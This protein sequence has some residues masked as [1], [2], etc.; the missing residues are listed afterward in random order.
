MDHSFLSTLVFFTG[1][2]ANVVGGAL[3]H[4]ISIITITICSDLRAQ[5]TTFAGWP[6]VFLTLFGAIAAS[7]SEKV[8]KSR[9]CPGH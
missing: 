7:K 1:N 2:P 5:P 9:K 4:W 3:R 8:L 6:V